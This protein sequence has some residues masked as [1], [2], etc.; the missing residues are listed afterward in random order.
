MSSIYELID[1]GKGG[2]LRFSFTMM[3]I[4]IENET[5]TLLTDEKVNVLTTVPW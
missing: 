4:S 5:F 3:L 1:P 2:N